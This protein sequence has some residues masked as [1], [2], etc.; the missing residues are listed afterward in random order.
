MSST[1]L[2]HN[3]YARLPLRHD[4]STPSSAD[5]SSS[6]P[7]P[8]HLPA[9][10]NAYPQPS[11]PPPTSPLPPIPSAVH[12]RTASAQPQR[13]IIDTNIRSN[14]LDSH[15]GAIAAG[16]RRDDNSPDPHEFYRDSS[17][18]Q[19]D[20]HFDNH[21]AER[22]HRPPLFGELLL[23]LGYPP[24]GLPY[25]DAPRRYRR[26][27]EGSMHSPNPVFSSGRR[28]P[29]DI[30]SPSSP[31]AWYLGVTPSLE[32]VDNMSRRPQ[33]P[34]AHHRRARS[35]FT[36]IP[37]IPPTSSQAHLHASHLS[38]TNGSKHPISPTNPKRGRSQQS[39]IPLSTRRLSSATNSGGSSPSTRRS[40]LAENSPIHRFSPPKGISGIPRP[41]GKPATSSDQPAL[42]PP[43]TV[44]S[45]HD[46]PKKDPGGN[47]RLKV[48]VSAPPPKKSPPL[49]SS[50]P[51]MPVSAAST[52][53]SR[54]KVADR[55]LSNV[56]SSAASSAAK[57]SNVQP[58]KIPEL[59]GIDLAARRERIQRALSS[60]MR[61]LD[62]N[63]QN[64]AK[65]SGSRTPE[66]RTNSSTPNTDRVGR[67]VLRNGSEQDSHQEALSDPMEAQP[68]VQ[69]ESIDQKPRNHAIAPLTLTTT[70]LPQVCDE[71]TMT[72]ET[73]FEEDASPTLGIPDNHEASSVSPEHKSLPHHERMG[74]LNNREEKARV[75]EYSESQAAETE[76]KEESQRMFDSVL[77]LRDR[78]SLVSSAG[79]E[80]IQIM[81][82]QMSNLPNQDSTLN[83]TDQPVP[84]T[85]HS[86]ISK[87]PKLVNVSPGNLGGSSSQKAEAGS[88]GRCLE[89]TSLLP[90]Y[91]TE[92]SGGQRQPKDQTPHQ[93]PPSDIPTPGTGR[94][95]LDSDQYS[96]INRV[97]D[98]Y[99][100]STSVSPLLFQNLQQQLLSGSPEI[101]RQAGWD[102]KAVTQLYMQG[103]SGN[104][105][106]D[107]ASP[108]RPPNLR[109]DSLEKHDLLSTPMI[110]PHDASI[111]PATTTDAECSE[112]DANSTGIGNTYAASSSPALSKESE[113]K[114]Q[115]PARDPQ[116][117]PADPYKL[118][119]EPLSE[120]DWG[121]LQNTSFFPLMEG[122]ESPEYRPTPPPKDWENEQPAV[123]DKISLAKGESGQKHETATAARSERG[124][125]YSSP[126][127][128]TGAGLG[129]AINVES[130]GD[131]PTVPAL[132]NLYPPPLPA[133][134]TMQSLADRSA[135]AFSP[136][137]PSVY[138]EQPSSNLLSSAPFESILTEMPT[139]EEG[140]P[141]IEDMTTQQ[142]NE[143]SRP[144]SSQEQVLRDS[145]ASSGHAS[146][147]S[148]EHRR[149]TRRRLLIKELVDTE[150][151]F[152]QDMK[153]IQSIY[154]E[155]SSAVDI[156]TAD[157]VR[158]LFGNTDE[159]VIFSEGFLDALKQAAASVYVMPKQSRWRLKSGSVSTA[160]SSVINEGVLTGG[161]E[162][163]EEEKDRKTLIGETFMQHLSAMEKVYGDYLR[164][165]EA[166]NKK[167]Q[168]LTP[169]PKVAI[170]LRECHACH[171]DI[172]SAWDLDSLL[173]KPV[174][175]ILKYPLLLQNLI[176]ETP[177]DH[178]DYKS[179][180]SSIREMKDTSHRINEMKRRAELVEQVVSRK[181]KDSDVRGGFSK[182]IGRRTEKFRQQVGLSDAI[183]DKGY[184]QVVAKFGPHFFQLHV[185]IR[186][187][188]SYITDVQTYVDCFHNFA[189]ALEGILE[190]SHINH[191]EVE[192]RW[193]N[194]A[195]V[196]R[197]ISTI[198]LPEH[199]N[200]VRKNIIEPMTSL[201][202]LHEGP[203]KVMQKRNKRLI[204]YSRFKSIKDRGDKPDKKTQEQADQFMALNDALKEE[205]PKLYKLTANLVAAC[206]DKF[207]HLQGQWQ[208]EWQSR[209]ET[210]LEQIKSPGRI[211]DIIDQFS[212]DFSFTEAQLLCLGICNGSMLAEAANFLSPS[213]TLVNDES[214]RPS[215][216][217]GSRSRGLSLGSDASPSLPPP[218]LG[219]RHS[220]NFSLSPILGPLTGQQTGSHLLGQ[221]ALERMRT[222]SN[223]S[224]FFTPASPPLGKRSSSGTTVAQ[225]L[226]RP[227][228]PRSST[229]SV[230]SA[231]HQEHPPLA[232]PT[233][234]LSEVFSSAM[235]MS[236]SPPTS[237]P[238]SPVH[239]ESS[240]REFRVLFLAA[241]V[242][243]F[244]I[245]RARREAGYPYLTYV[246]GEVFDVI[247]E[248]GELWLARNQD[249]PTQQLGWIW[250]RHFAKLTND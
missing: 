88:D 200:A 22:Q 110:A 176:G 185:V 80:S 102:Q 12:V 37:A 51:R 62:R 161:Q 72:R 216:Y 207:V 241:S 225:D 190:V 32:G 248:K 15:F 77:Q 174:Q 5:G 244:N 64:K 39:K 137:S 215:L 87:P 13:P 60:S 119:P 26:G 233:R 111:T 33:R 230:Y 31:T 131:S 114:S 120:Q 129:L 128:S 18:L 249:D 25:G 44:R 143:S 158:V 79:E 54:A 191:P 196:V 223:S 150:Y 134:S 189:S 166:A 96:T 21:F 197:E 122:E 210:V 155:T 173:V 206:L 169:H 213:T 202:A 73:E 135:T 76:N 47:A 3:H 235:P 112:S 104:R 132:P 78:T 38:P 7:F 101:A 35:D 165:H 107:A 115:Q 224:G 242:Y 91:N 99:Q 98:A 177:K 243:E 146:L 239:A 57:N 92:T 52:V 29:L 108:A 142:E 117:S 221:S 118:L 59:G 41:T 116:D 203:Q 27:S 34:S 58:K 133:Q 109:L 222:G 63:D 209:L 180:E 156:L 175:R 198:S 69:N 48:Y 136:P 9:V 140:L 16:L 55:F 126:L 49:R 24:A 168:S 183:E 56:N 61:E 245:D 70:G 53:A 4:G 127:G 171:Q 220:G 94:W 46:N 212:G 42:P 154:K 20:N 1:N 163:T 74:H 145:V 186:D 11:S 105:W 227:T 36:G 23:N 125:L 123:P 234:L 130:S 149:L 164:N 240:Q 204:D 229:G 40:S 66:T 188:D 17:F 144:G 28:S 113:M 65:R 194:F 148:P 208:T 182:A 84:A 228:F 14:P 68:Q 219:Q 178:P 93:I 86:T 45:R 124:G 157:D 192:R 8:A 170:W 218:D 82:E 214:R 19:H 167:L 193:R 50:R 226:A 217:G 75:N 103:F 6:Y 247:A 97:L 237:Q 231:S 85:E 83:D 201:L 159:I 89:T 238:T 181:R 250:S 30:V 151:S 160:N 172:T 232:S 10:N 100:D 211:S 138:S 106:R 152:N 162:S 195:K 43:Q 179:L 141:P 184:D 90:E 236:D 139:V 199:Q 246:P 95:T 187:V 67:G 147:S 2:D 81:L 205:L 121:L 153:V 71:E